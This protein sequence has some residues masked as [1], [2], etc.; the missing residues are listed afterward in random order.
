MVNSISKG[1]ATPD[2]GWCR[3]SSQVH[4]H[5]FPE[6]RTHST[7]VIRKTPSKWNPWLIVQQLSSKNMKCIHSRILCGHE[8][9]RCYSFSHIGQILQGWCWKQHHLN[10]D[11]GGQKVPCDLSWFGALEPMD[12]H[13]FSTAIHGFSTGSPRLW[14]NGFL[15]KTRCFGKSPRVATGSPRLPTGYPRVLVYRLSRGL[16]GDHFSIKG[17]RKCINF[18][19]PTL[20]WGHWADWKPHWFGH[21]PCFCCKLWRAFLG[22]H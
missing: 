22:S 18:C 1:V 6:K 14:K 5:W 4:D 11:W 17:V 9:G 10:C 21:K 2:S 12:F 13:G 3:H 16:F 15:S 8:A 20:W 19:K 7:L